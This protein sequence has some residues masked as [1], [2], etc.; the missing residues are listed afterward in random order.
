MSGRGKYIRIANLFLLWLIVTM[1]TSAADGKVG[2][3]FRV[4]NAGSDVTGDGSPG[5]PYQTVNFA[6]T[7]ASAGDTVIVNAGFY[8]EQIVWP[9]N[10]GIVLRG[11]DKF[12]R[13]V[14]SSPFIGPTI[15]IGGEVFFDSTTQ[16]IDLI[17]T[18]GDSVITGPGVRTWNSTPKIIRCE[19]KGNFNPGG[20]GG[21]A[22]VYFD[23]FYAPSDIQFTD[24]TF[25]FNYADSGAGLHVI[26]GAPVVRRNRFE[27]NRAGKGGGGAVLRNCS[28]TV[29]EDNFLKQNQAPNGAGMYISDLNSD[30]ANNN[31]YRR[32][33]FIRN[34]ALQN[35]GGIFFEQSV[36]SV[37][38]ENNTLAENTANNSGGAF[39]GSDINGISFSGNLVINNKSLNF[40]AGFF[41]TQNSSVLFRSNIITGNQAG[42]SGGGISARNGSLI[43]VGGSPF[44]KNSLF[45]N[46]SG[47]VLNS[48]QSDVNVSTLS[49]NY[50]GTTDSLSIGTQIQIP[51]VNSPWSPFALTGNLITQKV[52]ADSQSLW[53]ADGKLE[54][55]VTGAILNDSSIVFR[56]TADTVLQI[57]NTTHRLTKHYFI[58][59]GNLPAP[60]YARLT[61]YY[62]PTELLAANVNNPQNL[63]IMYFDNQSASWQVLNSVV[64][65]PNNA[66][67][68]RI[69]VITATDW[70]LAVPGTQN[71]TL[72][73][74]SPVPNERS[75]DPNVNINILFQQPMNPQ[76]INSAAVRIHGDKSGTH[77]FQIFFDAA[78]NE[79][80][81][82]PD[83]P[84]LYGENVVVTLSDSL[85]TAAGIPLDNGFKW[86][87]TIATRGAT[88]QFTTFTDLS[89][90]R[91]VERVVAFDLTDDDLQ[92]LL[93]LDNSRS[94]LY[95]F[96][97][98]GNQQFMVTDSL[99]LVQTTKFVSAVD[100]DGDASTEVITAYDNGLEIFRYD[101]I[102][103]QFNQ[104]AQISFIGTGNLLDVKIADFNNDLIEDI[105]VLRS[106]LGT[107]R[108]RVYYGTSALNYEILTPFDRFVA[109][110]PTLM[111]LDDYNA[112]GLTDIMLN[113]GSS[114][115][116]TALYL[117]AGFSSFND[118]LFADKGNFFEHLLTENFFGTDPQDNALEVLVAGDLLGKKIG[119]FEIMQPQVNGNSFILQNLFSGNYPFNLTDITSGDVDGDGYTDIV[120]AF[121]N[122]MVYIY[123]NE[124]PQFALLDSLNTGLV[125]Q[126]VGIQDLDG[127]GDAEILTFD[128][129]N[130]NSI[131]IWWNETRGPRTWWV[132]E[133]GTPPY[134]GDAVSPFR[135][136][137]TA[138]TRSL[139]GDTIRIR[140]GNYPEQL[141]IDKRLYITG[142][143]FGATIST[144]GPSPFDSALIRVSGNF[145]GRM[146]NLYIMSFAASGYN[147]IVIDGVDSLLILDRLKLFGFETGLQAANASV[148]MDTV[149]LDSNRIGM[150]VLNSEIEMQNSQIH[151]SYSAGI[152]LNNSTLN[153]N[154]FDLSENGVAGAGGIDA[155]ANSSLVLRQGGLYGNYGYG[156][157]AAGSKVDIRYC[158]IDSTISDGT[159]NNPGIG[160]AVSNSDSVSIRNT[161]LVNNAR[162][163]IALNNVSAIVGNCFFAF[164][165]SV[166]MNNGAAL[167][168]TNFSGLE[169][170]SNI[171]Y[172]NA[173]GVNLDG[174]AGLFSYNDFFLN[175]QDI[176]GVG[177]GTGNFFVDPYIVYNNYP[178]VT[179]HTSK[180]SSKG[181]GLF[182]IK[183][184][185]G[186]PLIDEG[187]P[188]FFDRDSSRSDI[189]MFGD[190]QLEFTLDR[191]PQLDAVLNDSSV[192]LSWTSGVDMPFY[193]GAA[194][195]R[196]DQVGFK[197]SPQNRIAVIDGPQNTFLDPFF[198]G[199]K[200]VYYR[201]CYIDS[202]GGTTGYSNR[203]EVFHA[204]R[205]L[206]FVP[207]TL[208]V[209][210]FMRDSLAVSLNL[211]N[212][213]SLGESVHI[214][215]VRL[216][217]FSLRPDS[218]LIEPD[219]SGSIQI[220]FRGMELPPDSVLSTTITAVLDSD[221]TIQ[222]QAV[223]SMKVLARHQLTFIP[224]TLL[225]PVAM[226]TSLPLPVTLLNEGTVPESLIVQTPAVPWLQVL[227][228][229]LFVPPDSSTTLDIVLNSANLA[230]DN[231]Y[232]T[233]LTVQSQSDSNVTAVLPVFMH[234]FP[235]RELVFVPDSV[236]VQVG[237]RD[238]LKRKVT[239]ENTGSLTESVY[240]NYTSK[241][242]FRLDRQNMNIAAG[243]AGQVEITFYAWL[244]PEGTLLNSEI[245]ARITA[246]SSF[247]A[248]LPISLLVV[249]RDISAPR[250]EF[251][252]Q[253]PDTVNQS[254]LSYIF[255]GNDSVDA[256]LFSSSDRLRYHYR[257]ESLTANGIETKEDTTADTR[258]DFYGLRDGLYRFSVAAIDE[259]MNGGLG[260]SDTQLR[261]VKTTRIIAGRKTIRKRKWQMISLPRLTEQ[262]AHQYF[263]NSLI[264]FK[265][266]ENGT[267]ISKENE[268]LRPG[269]GYWIFNNE[270]A[271]KNMNDL[272]FVPADSVFNIPVQTGWNQIGSPWN[273]ATRW[274]DIEV[275]TTGDTLGLLQA[276]SDG[277]IASG[278]YYHKQD[279]VVTYEPAFTDNSSL[280]VPWRGYWLESNQNVHLIFGS[281]VDTASFRAGAT[282]AADILG[283]PLTAGQSVVRLKV[284]QN[285]LADR[286]NYFGI[287]NSAEN[288]PLFM[289]EAGEPPAADA[290]IK[291]YARSAGREITTDVNVD[292]GSDLYEWDLYLQSSI[293]G[294][295]VE[296][297]WDYAEA[298]ELYA[299]LYDLKN[300]EWFELSQR[301]DY[302]IKSSTKAHPFKLYLSRQADFKPPVLPTNYA[303]YQNYPNPFN[304]STRIGFDIPYFAGE[305]QTRLAVYDVLGRQVAVLMNTKL[306]P[307]KYTVSWNGRNA[308]GTVLAS[309]VYF[310]RVESG[311]FS[312]TR[313]MILIK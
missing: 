124:D 264:A 84:F 81:L 7:I 62:N 299:F 212:L 13:P 56:T 163:G 246:D 260:N 198:T 139:P 149:E 71:D 138:L 67:S 51:N 271:T 277:I 128:D 251:V 32:N 89:H 112:D 29:F 93:V 254:A 73:V 126:Q 177:P 161:L 194:V 142:E 148:K 28:G 205:E 309:G 282:A 107:T 47:S 287:M 284:R 214:D 190:L 184:A 31:I 274:S 297:S 307:G 313:K 224:D 46:T 232:S 241:P 113:M 195:F 131:R 125:S 298:S 202:A 231:T 292:D 137:N 95:L 311:R 75:V 243:E 109:L 55:N 57:P 265:R 83:R 90:A 18:H 249:D 221:G 269:L 50:W 121:S 305:Q 104:L 14:I 176:V 201:V 229:Q 35:G 133:F 108:L 80:W 306:K 238:S 60:D 10:Q 22:E 308:T 40:G 208:N 147:G 227:Q 134:L 262:T 8:P 106:S 235:R 217:W 88:A 175:N 68:G 16:L 143:Q 4:D 211:F 105:A 117:N 226:E 61:L 53:F 223:L 255:A 186:S 167:R 94:N 130:S 123:H 189:G 26:S 225:A 114:I 188:R 256:T 168:A 141:V 66:V 36:L 171:F 310:Y 270:P 116:E 102:N 199:G 245:T 159:V 192:S 136:I 170:F 169:I 303:L 156:I 160:L 129:V 21:G 275:V 25:L 23:P 300:G 295:P 267:Y 259:N 119:G 268:V 52:K 140:P 228:N 85:Q 20:F 257:F 182:L 203:V 272:P 218:L 135:R 118:P 162:D 77:G 63:R 219:S 132:D 185:P 206:A 183:L 97:N 39:Y 98:A 252:F 230:Y 78:N 280:V 34:T 193:R 87:F 258:L 278:I 48:V 296:F 74:V 76:T 233:E 30:L 285:N 5:N 144:P 65:E 290:F 281:K 24:C 27:K 289:Q 3:A 72:V 6:L 59:T 263:G 100:L 207:D 187:D 312:A 197:P 45:H 101:L 120:M 64:D 92:D 216:P 242:W 164:N 9:F 236:G 41:L 82:Q 291:L 220:L 222:A 200:K 155:Q 122:G 42:N 210:V 157:K 283:K 152:R 103:G 151:R 215:Y 273:W 276:M 209:Q 38:F 69:E 11:S 181:D 240:L 146:E 180:D 99:S 19:F 165:D 15:D 304:P 237:L 37:L 172:Q 293:S 58:D 166:G 179:K 17:I 234:V 247:R 154:E 96:T 294:K 302:T 110:S 286:Y 173:G 301:D 153:A 191:R 49:Y 1:T 248:F 250:T 266:Y 86:R 33:S 70:A 261:A 244:V 178:F 54:L 288:I 196:S 79:L 12:N 213:G 111:N 204:L 115:F 91:Q 239:I 158:E 43:S 279:T 2:Q 174:P 145:S 253:P 44:A 150:R 127:D